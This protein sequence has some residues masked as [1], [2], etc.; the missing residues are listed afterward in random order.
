V[1]DDLMHPA[2]FTLKADPSRTVVRPFFSEDP[3]GFV[4]EGHPRVQ[5]I[6]DRVLALIDE[7]VRDAIARPLQNL[8]E[9]HRHVEELLLCRFEELRETINRD[10]ITHERSLLIGAYFSSEYAFESAALFNPSMILHEDQSGLPADTIR[11]VMALRGIGEGHI[12][13]V[14]FRVGTW[15]PND[16]ITVEPPTPHG[17]PPRVDRSE[18]ERED[19]M[20]RLVFP[21]SEDVSETVLFPVTASQKGGIE[22]LRL[23][24][25]TDDDGSA[26]LF[27]TYTAFS[28][29]DM[30]QEML[31][32]GDF[33][34]IEMYPLRGRATY[35]KG[36]AL[37]PRRIDG[38]YAMIG[39]QDNENLFYLISDDLHEWN[40]AVRIIEP[41]F[42]WDLVQMGNC[43]SPIE[44]EEGWLLLTHGVG[45][46]R[47]YCIG[48]CLLD[49]TDPTKVLA[50]T[51]RPLLQPDLQSR[52]GYVP[53]VVYSCG[54]LVHN[55]TLLLPYGV[56]DQYTA[57]ASIALSELL[58]AMD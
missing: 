20:I 22:D 10:A 2:S 19:G 25:F 30:R 12:S 50:R 14:T 38:R 24:H 26:H 39:R 32:V 29:S 13:S 35:N 3:A 9:R 53:N 11:F 49:K 18:P 44:I 28:G 8:S 23:V 33:K 57:F 58:C 41:R 6:A 4:I 37:F 52:G 56:A 45:I 7:Q 51:V 16:D 1:D 46:F 40:D 42:P 47:R 27:G 34:T 21:E 31:H 43:G 55:R 5:R 17:V 48:A 15:G 36:M 54:G